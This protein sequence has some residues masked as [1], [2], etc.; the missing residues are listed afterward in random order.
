[1]PLRGAA[2]EG[3][4]L[5]GKRRVCGPTRGF[6]LEYTLG[7]REI[8]VKR[9]SCQM[10]ILRS[11]LM[12][13]SPRGFAEWLRNRSRAENTIRQYVRDLGHCMEHPRGMLGKLRDKL[14]PKTVRRT[15]AVL[16]SWAK[17]AADARLSAELDD[18]LLPPA[19]RAHARTP[20]PVEDWLKL[21]RALPTAVD[22]HP[23]Q[24][25]IIEIM[26]MRGMR[27]GDV[28]RLRRAQIVEGLQ[29]GVLVAEQKRRSRQEYSVGPIEPQLRRLLDWPAWEQVVDLVL[30]ED[31]EAVDRLA[32]GGMAVWRGVQKVAEQA[33][34]EAVYP[35]R[36]RRTYATEFL[37][38]VGGNLELLR[39][40]MGW[41]DLAT[42]ASYADHDRREELDEVAAGM[43][44]KKKG[45]DG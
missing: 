43:L 23:V 17:Y 22:V 6:R 9:E 36:L 11:H 1:M 33:G 20:M 38:E 10:D 14:A 19:R 41:A 13:P 3:R 25:V 16:R 39:Q 31:S 29:T 12:D 30:P 32:A 7:T 42:A 24:R 4:G 37:T 44:R 27:V 8:A 45:S 28:L 35:H 18:V 15:Y 40:H 5:K 26:C 34:I 21:V 2:K